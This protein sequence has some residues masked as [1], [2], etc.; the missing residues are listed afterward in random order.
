MK[1]N[2]LYL[3]STN[4]LFFL[5]ENIQIN[6]T[7]KEQKRKNISI[8]YSTI[9]IYWLELRK[10]QQNFPKNDKSIFIKSK[11]MNSIFFRVMNFQV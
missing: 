8:E 4:S 2:V 10:E 6:F 1:Q 7:N 11:T 5:F 9:S 3:N